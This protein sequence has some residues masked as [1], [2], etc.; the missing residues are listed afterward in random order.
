ME[1]DC[2]KLLEEALDEVR[3]YYNNAKEFG[4]QKTIARIESKFPQIKENEEDERIKKIITDSVFYQYGAGAEYKDV[5]DYL[6]KLEKQNAIP[7]RETILGIWELGNLWKDYPEERNGL[8]QLKYI[9]KHWLEKCDYQ[10]G[11]KPDTRD[12]DDLQLL[13]FIYDLLNQIKWKDGWAMSKEECLRRLNDYRPQKPAGWSEDIIRKAV[14]EVGLTQHQ[15][16][17]FKANV[18]PPKQEWSEEDERKLQNCIKIVEKWEEDYDIDD[19][20]YSSVFKSLRPKSHWKPS[21]E[22]MEAL[23]TASE[24]N[25][26]LG[27]ILNNLYYD[28]KSNYSYEIH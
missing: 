2:K 23:F 14:K 4:D 16:D 20:R 3:L 12:A 27:S 26:K 24:R 7:S 10:K 6:G 18:F 9:Q 28:L 21:E 11:Q 15:I 8:T 5:L 13:G 17:W 19:A 22:Q 1:K 25:D